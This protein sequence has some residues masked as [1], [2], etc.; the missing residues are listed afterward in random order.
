M[1]KDRDFSVLNIEGGPLARIAALK[2][3]KVQAVPLT[4][5]QRVQAENDGFTMLLDTRETLTEIPSTVVASTREFV[6][7]QS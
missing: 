7:F 3:G 1:I 6:R 2:T 4:P 5:G